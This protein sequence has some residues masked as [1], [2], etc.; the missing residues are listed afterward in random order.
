M[1]VCRCTHARTHAHT[2]TLPKS[3]IS[4][5]NPAFKVVEN[6]PPP[7]TRSALWRTVHE[8]QHLFRRLEGLGH[9]PHERRELAEILKSQI[10]T[11]LLC[12]ITQFSSM[13]TV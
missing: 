11:Y 9:L 10:P 13:P 6:L 3:D 4:Q 5:F 7:P 12:E 2:H 8:R 1:Y